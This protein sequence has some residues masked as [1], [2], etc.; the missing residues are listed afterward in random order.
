MYPHPAQQNKQIN[1]KNSV[2]ADGYHGTCLHLGGLWH[3]SQSQ[4]PSETLSQ[5]TKESRTRKTCMNSLGAD[6]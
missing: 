3:W 1:K 2:W 6:M 5:K 4:Q